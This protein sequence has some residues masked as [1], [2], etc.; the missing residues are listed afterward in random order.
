MSRQLIM[1]IETY[2]KKS[3]EWKVLNLY[4][5]FIPIGPD[6]TKENVVEFSPYSLEYG[7]S[8]PVASFLN[9]D[10][11]VE[12]DDKDNEDSYI[13]V[14]EDYLN[15]VYNVPS[16]DLS[17]ELQ[18][19][20]K[21]A[22]K[23]YLDMGF[24]TYQRQAKAVTLRSAYFIADKYQFMNRLLIDIETLLTTAEHVSMFTA[25]NTDELVSN[26]GRQ[27]RVIFYIE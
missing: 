11:F 26:Y 24:K 12:V 19:L 7:A 20:W 9:G 8:H 3:D 25:S 27:V 18:Q 21:E 23:Q 13:T 1:Y 5:K 14:D 16:D 2:D 4:R 6:G 15:Y 17:K 10:T 22:E